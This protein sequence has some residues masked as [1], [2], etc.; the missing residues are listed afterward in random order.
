M[1]GLK[2]A[3]KDAEMAKRRIIIENILDQEHVVE[4]DDKFIFF[5]LCKEVEF[6][7]DYFEIIDKDFDK[8]KTPPAKDLRTL[9]IGKLTDEEF[10]RL[11]TSFDTI[12]TIAILEIDEDLRS[13]EKV[14][15]EALL[16]SNKK[17]K[18]VLRKDE[19]HDGEFRTQKMMWL[20][21]VNTME[22][23]H[24][25]N[26]VLLKLNVETVYFSPRLSTDRKRIMQQ[27]KPGEEILVMFSGCAPYPCVF[28]K[29]TPAKSIV[30][31]EIN[32]EGHRY[33]L[34]NVSLNKLK[35][36]TLI[37][38][39]VKIEVPKL[40][41]TF[42]RILMP[43]PKSAED[44]LETAL[45]AAKR[46]TIIHFYNFLRED[47]FE[48]AERMVD[49]ACKSAGRTWKKLDLVKCGQHAPRTF[50]ICL[51]FEVTN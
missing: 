50:R 24:K 35:N 31:I 3:L 39:D 32:P 47:N 29:N 15:A 36:V 12:G 44:F 33:G 40:G 9:L 11:K 38:G 19:K 25:E 10:Y 13:K 27:V 8:K 1:L 23:I 30:G 41:R 5:P 14:I 28:S 43:L 26:G 18:T 6:K 34:E 49:A 42:D 2:V 17:I 7:E 51:D 21:G 46:G 45:L 22:T 16:E 4:K 20:A 37:N 48:E